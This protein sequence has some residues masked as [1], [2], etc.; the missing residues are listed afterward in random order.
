MRVLL[1]GLMALGTPGRLRAVGGIDVWACLPMHPFPPLR[2]PGFPFQ[3]TLTWEV[4]GQDVNEFL[5]VQGAQAFARAL[6]RPE[7]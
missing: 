1:L 6:A 5:E 7:P 3:S 4:L 2:A